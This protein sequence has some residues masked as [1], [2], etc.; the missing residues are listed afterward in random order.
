M[1]TVY[2]VTVRDTWCGCPDHYEE[3]CE[4]T[5]HAEAMACFRQ[6][7]RE[8]SAANGYEGFKVKMTQRDV[9]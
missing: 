4:T 7:K 3:E 8:Y 2:L 9:E 1:T 6:W 5:S